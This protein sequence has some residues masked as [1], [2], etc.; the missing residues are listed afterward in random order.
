MGQRPLV[1]TLERIRDSFNPYTVDAIAR[2]AARIGRDRLFEVLREK[3]AVPERLAGA[4]GI[5]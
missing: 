3:S 2:T 4:R 5:P 1:E